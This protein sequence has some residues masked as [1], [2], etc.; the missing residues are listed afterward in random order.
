MNSGDDEQ[1]SK[2]QSQEEKY[3]TGAEKT[4]TSTKSEAGQGALEE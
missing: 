1:Y 3:K 2:I 4:R